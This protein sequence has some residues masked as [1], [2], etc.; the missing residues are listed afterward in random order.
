M[1]F[2][3]QI[4]TVVEFYADLAKFGQI[5]RLIML[6]RKTLKMPNGRILR[7]VRIEQASGNKP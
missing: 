7:R 1:S 5:Y 2:K 4:S 3:H 6:R